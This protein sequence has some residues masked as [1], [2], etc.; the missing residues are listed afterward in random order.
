[1]EVLFG[2]L[3]ELIGSFVV[4][5]VFAAIFGFYEH[6]FAKSG[7]RFW[8]WVVGLVLIGMVFWWRGFHIW[9]PYIFATLMLGFL[10]YLHWNSRD[11]AE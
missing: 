4:E 3:F 11:P 10:G 1:M 8:I 2:F 7:K 5:V 6:F 9:P